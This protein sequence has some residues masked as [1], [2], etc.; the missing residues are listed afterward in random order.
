VFRATLKSLLARKLRLV[1]SGVAVILGVSFIAGS[2]ILTD[3]I[4]N[5]F[6][7]LFASANQ[8]VAVV[9]RGQETAVSSS[10]RQPVPASLLATVRQL[11]GVAAAEPNIGGYAQLLDKKGKTYPYQNGPPAIG[12]AFD[13]NQTVSEDNLVAGRA[14]TGPGEMVI[15]RH[16]AQETHYHVGD[17]APVFTR[18]PR[19]D[20]KIVGIYVEGT[21]GNQGGASLIGFDLA[22]AQRIMGK[23]GEYDAILVASERGANDTQLLR[24]IRTALPDTVEAVSGAQ[25]AKDQADEIKGGFL[26]FFQVVLLI[27]GGVAVFVGAFIIFNTFSMLIGQ[28]IRELALL[29]AVGA[30]RGQVVR[31]VLI[32][33]VAVGAAGSTIGLGFGTLIAYGLPKLVKAAGGGSIPYGTLVFA[34]RTF[35]WTYVVGVGITALAALVPA[36][37]ASRIPP[38]A[39]LRDAV[40]TNPSQRRPAIIGGVIFG[41]GVLAMIP[42]LRGQFALLGLGA[43]LIFIGVAVLSSVIARPVVHLVSAPFQRTVPGRLARRNAI[44]NPRRTATTA[45]ALMIG[46][47]L[48]SAV[49]VLGA[50]VKTSLR[51]IIRTAF[52]ADFDVASRS[53]DAGLSPTVAQQLAKQPEL[54]QVDSLGFSA[55]LVEGH[56]IDQVTALPA[57]AIGHTVAVKKFAG[58]MTLA[59]GGLLI[60][61]STSDKYSLRAGEDVKVQYERGGP[62]TLHVEGVYEDNGLA[63]PALVDQSERK[64]FSVRLDGVVLVKGANGVPLSKVRAAIERVTDN[65]PT[66]K[67][68]SRDEFIGDTV[69]FIDGFIR[70][71][72]ALLILSV[73]IAV[74]GVVNTLI[75]SVIERTRE[76]GLLRAVGLSRKQMRKM[77]RRE[78]IVV[79]VF[80]AVLGIVVGSGLGIAIVSALH[81]QG[82]T[83]ITF[84]YVRL[85]LLVVFAVLAGIIAAIG[86]ARRA[87][88]L[89]VLEAIATE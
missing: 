15:D 20:Y 8:K 31:S 21:S 85:A 3:T 26:K 69:K 6:D 76:L 35:I 58:S 1:L 32:E 52:A 10:Q 66:A 60:D 82:I 42:G 25:S 44:R 36:W 28:R 45:G 77:V 49:S 78:S 46:L 61:R 74:L 62:Q 48:I 72:T 13:A 51:G 37:R 5:V 84:P 50:S 64:Y 27:F 16:T 57:R 55:A 71:L 86:P 11:P 14:P 9:I 18:E 63:G 34:P 87:A 22:T 33:S 17:I 43:I 80:G 12:F 59:P 65:Y 67:V 68:Q 70:F 56:K 89:N 30:S 88:R 83:T 47:A 23:P 39:A 40:L 24:E 75:L 79:A 7:N 54:G 29:R 19:K 73:A 38:V 81:K 53:F 41:L 4:G 2:L